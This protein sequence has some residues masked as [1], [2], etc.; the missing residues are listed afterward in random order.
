L[1]QGSQVREYKNVRGNSRKARGE[2]MTPE[3]Q[4]LLDNYELKDSTLIC[5]LSEHG[6]FEEEYFWKYYNCVTELIK[7]NMDQPLEREMTKLIHWTH[8]RIIDCFLWHYNPEDQFTINNFPIVNFSYFKERLDFMIDGYYG[9]F[10]L[11]EKEFGDAI[12]NPNYPEL[13]E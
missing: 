12:K 8:K 6:I 1:H 4:I 7:N 2:I 9:N 13:Y 10:I 3:Y 5:Y 11:N